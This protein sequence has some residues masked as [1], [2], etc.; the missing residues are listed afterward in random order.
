[1]RDSAVIFFGAGVVAYLVLAAV[2][3]VVDM[4]RE[5]R[6]LRRRDAERRSR[7]GGGR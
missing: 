4:V 5:A 1:M 3:T 7:I 2:F 6:R